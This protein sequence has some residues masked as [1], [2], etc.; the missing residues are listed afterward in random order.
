MDNQITSL[1]EDNSGGLSSIRILMLSWGLGV[2][3]IWAFSVIMAVC[4]GNA[5]PVVLT[6]EVVTILMGITGIKMVQRPFEK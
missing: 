3:A 2:L 6:P 5:I 1:L 4:S